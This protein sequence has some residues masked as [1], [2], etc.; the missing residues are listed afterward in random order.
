MIVFTI[1]ALWDFGE[2][3]EQRL[4]NGDLFA[5][6]ENDLRDLRSRVLSVP[7]PGIEGRILPRTNPPALDENDDFMLPPPAYQLH[8][9]VDGGDPDGM[10]TAGVP[11]FVPPTHVDASP[12]EWFY[13]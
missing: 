12:Y 3:I 8:E 7:R 11:D 13:I 4:R 6:F 1:S 2:Q 9:D 5:A 10:R